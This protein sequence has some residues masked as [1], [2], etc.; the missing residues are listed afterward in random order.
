MNLAF[1]LVDFE[2]LLPQ[3]GQI[4]LKDIMADE[5]FGISKDSLEF[6]EICSSNWD[7]KGSGWF[8]AEPDHFGRSRR[9]ESFVPRAFHVGNKGCGF[10]ISDIV[11][12]GVWRIIFWCNIQ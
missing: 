12:R 9:S 6:S 5:N 3:F 8:G 2:T 1:V 7:A 11:Y 4:E 10:E